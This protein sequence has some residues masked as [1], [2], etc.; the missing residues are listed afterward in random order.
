MKK[1]LALLLITTMIMTV[2]AGITV[3]AEYDDSTPGKVIIHGNT[4]GDHGGYLARNLYAWNAQPI[5]YGA[6]EWWQGG[7]Y[8]QLWSNWAGAEVVFKTKISH[9]TSAK[10]WAFSVL[11]TGNFVF[12]F[13]SDDNGTAEIAGTEY[14]TTDVGHYYYDLPVPPETK[15][16]GVT[17]KTGAWS[18]IR[19]IEFTYDE[20]D[21]P[22]DLIFSNPVFTSGLQNGAAITSL[23]TGFIQGSISMHNSNQTDTISPMVFI[24]LKTKPNSSIVNMSTMRINIAPNTTGTAEG[25]FNILDAAAH[26]IEIY[27]WDTAAGMDLLYKYTF[28]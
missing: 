8:I 5:D 21:N 24:V 7:E 26:K 16:I 3:Q 9:I 6:H 13:Y 4:W 1:L 18:I 10:V 12:R 23:E 11:D 15:S 17:T 2:M 22:D 14:H 19:Y 25:G 27:V 28:E 20:I